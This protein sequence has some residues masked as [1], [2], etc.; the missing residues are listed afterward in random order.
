[1][2]ELC[3]TSVL[4]RPELQLLSERN[5]IGWGC[6]LLPAGISRLLAFAVNARR[7]L[8]TE[9]RVKPA[10]FAQTRYGLAFSLQLVQC[11]PFSLKF[12]ISLSLIYTFSE[13]NTIETT[14]T[15]TL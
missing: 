12:T 14:R 2:G 6:V 1:M 4:I 11:L 7:A 13:T 10:T 15:T 9:R 3:V 5:R 8:L